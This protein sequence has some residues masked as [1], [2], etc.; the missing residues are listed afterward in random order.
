MPKATS[1]IL[2][3]TLLGVSLTGT[4]S[5]KADLAG[6]YLAARSADFA[7]DFVPAQEYL[8]RALA[9]D[10]ENLGLA[11]A[12]VMNAVALGQVEAA[13]PYAQRL[14]L[15]KESSQVAQLVLLVDHLKRG[16]YEPALK[17]LDPKSQLGGALLDPLLRGWAKL[18]Q[19]SM[20][21]AVAEFEA[22]AKT[23]GL[24]A[25]GDYS[26]ALA[27]ANVGDFDGAEA[28]LAKKD[29][30]LMTTRRGALAHIQVLSQLDR[31]ADA[32]ARLEEAFGGVVDPELDD[33][34]ARL[35]KGE[36]LPFDIVTSPQDGMAETFHVLSIILQG[37]A[38][39]AQV[40]I[41]SRMAEFLRPDHPDAKLV[42]AGTLEAMGQEE[43]AIATYDSV[44]AD[45]LIHFAAESGKVQALYRLDKKAEA[46][47][48]QEALVKEFPKMLGAQVAL[49][50]LYQREEMFEKAA[51]TYRKAID[52]LPRV[53]SRHWSLF[54]SL[55]SVL[56]RAKKWDEAEVA[57]RRALELDP[58]QAIVLNYLG[59]SML[60]RHVNIPEAFTLIEKAV[61]KRPKDG[62][63]IDSLAWG[64]F[65][66]GQYQEALGHMEKASL[67][68]PVDP[69]VTDHL[70]DVYWAVGR[71]NEARFQ[72]RR[73]LSFD[74]TEADAA[75]IRLKLEKGL[76][77]VLAE[78]GLPAL[79]ERTKK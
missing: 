35:S 10:P 31:N 49:A 23:R 46:L 45:S 3:L 4:G 78:E 33:L 14:G 52:L 56:E 66:T 55:G 20:S 24:E 16:E 34:R 18:G 9:N 65:L 38:P 44:P 22:L 30:A 5:A 53:E 15:S 76:D 39:Q 21:Q 72:W 36:K 37:E 11:E 69:I 17:I 41:H 70:G 25:F 71:V 67:L 57:L 62:F 77:A 50:D 73:A 42:S 12:M 40:L 60:D 13:L 75:R 29:N 27:L 26:H 63:I 19:G 2:A 61:A 28:L 68:M 7:S 48:A 74:P 64:Y 6:P 59:Y 58:D 79:S 32:L 1:L 8:T 47:A 51:A 43:L 54:F